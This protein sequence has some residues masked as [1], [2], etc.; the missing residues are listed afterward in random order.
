MFLFISGVKSHAQYGGNTVIVDAPMSSGQ[1][2]VYAVNECSTGEALN[3]IVTRDENLEI[4]VLLPPDDY[5]PVDV[6]V[7]GTSLQL[8][9]TVSP[10]G[11]LQF[12]FPVNSIPPGTYELT[13]NGFVFFELTIEEPVDSPYRVIFTNLFDG[14]AHIAN[15]G[16]D[17]AEQVLLE[18]NDMLNRMVEASS[19]GEI[20]AYIADPLPQVAGG[21]AI[22]DD[23]VRYGD[24]VEAADIA[25]GADSEGGQWGFGSLGKRLDGTGSLLVM[26]YDDGSAPIVLRN[27]GE[28]S[29][30]TWLPDDS[31]IVYVAK[32]NGI[33]DLYMIDIETREE[34]RITHTEDEDIIEL[35]PSVSPDGTQLV[36]AVDNDGV[37]EL[38]TVEIEDGTPELLLADEFNNSFPAYSPDGKTIAFSSDRDGMGAGVYLYDIASGEIEMLVDTDVDEIQPAW[39]PDSDLIIYSAYNTDNGTFDL[40]VIPLDESYEPINITDDPAWDD[41]R[42]QI[43]RLP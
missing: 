11:E 3:L 33:T 8:L 27:D 21:V 20:Y 26:R 30:P 17:G 23:T 41:V 34:T 13:V 18:D 2:D 9:T 10:D 36:Y 7:V 25:D 39:S 15:S 38:W 4:T 12:D 1:Y 24:C 32:R 29:D 16:I 35:S 37:F 40:Y 28:F 6:S 14:E 22:V 19:D 43:I 42:P 5:L 31:Q